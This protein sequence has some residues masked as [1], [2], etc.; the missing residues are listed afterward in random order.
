MKIYYENQANWTTENYAELNAELN[1]LFCIV[2]DMNFAQKKAVRNYEAFDK[3]C[4]S[5]NCDILSDRTKALMVAI[6]DQQK[7]KDSI[8][9]LYP[10]LS[11]L[12]DTK[13]LKEPLYLSDEPYNVFNSYRNMNIYY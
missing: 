8:I 3:E 1:K 4:S 2:I 11:P 6:L 7:K 12:K 13:S 5:I 9:K 10:N